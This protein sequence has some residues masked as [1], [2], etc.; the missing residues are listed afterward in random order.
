MLSKRTTKAKPPAKSRATA[1]TKKLKTA[2]TEAPTAILF[3][4]L[5]EA[6]RA[7]CEHIDRWMHSATGTAGVMYGKAIVGYGSSVIRYADGREAPWFKIGFSPRKQALTLYGVL[8][9]ATPALLK[10]LGKHSCGKGCLYIK[11]LA[12]IDPAALEKIIVAAAQK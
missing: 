9:T 12:D 11:R 2:V 4:S 7:D 10:Q 3:A 8:S 5:D 6:T 1:A